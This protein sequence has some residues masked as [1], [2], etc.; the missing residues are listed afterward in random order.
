MKDNRG[1]MYT[2]EG[3]IGSLV[4]I[5]AVVFAMQSVVITP[6]SGGSVGAAERTDIRQQANDILLLA[7]QNDTFDLSRQIR[8]WSQSKRT[9]YEALNP[10]LGYA[11]RRP[12]GEFGRLL[13]RTFGVSAPEYNVI[14]HY[15]SRNGS[16]GT[17]STPLLVQ[18]NPEDNAV[19]ATHTVTLFDNQTLT[20]PGTGGVELWEYDTDPTDSDDG[21]Y[22]IPDAVDGPVYNVVEVR[23]IVW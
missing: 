7:A 6:S 8:Y 16:E 11:S 13:N 1:Q 21:Y 9:F 12:P 15:R 18:G 22:P 23:L 4:I 17:N 10:R 2:L 3:V 5:S 19:V 20:A 14:L